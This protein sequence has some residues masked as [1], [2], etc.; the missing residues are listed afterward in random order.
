[1]PPPDD[2]AQEK[3]ARRPWLKRLLFIAVAIE[4]TWLA[5]INAALTLPVTQDLLNRI[6]PEKF[7]VRWERAWSWYPGQVSAIKPFANGQSRRQQWQASVDRVD[8]RI[9]LL[10]LILKRVHISWGEAHNAEYR[11]RPRLK[12]DTDYTLLLPHYPEI[13]GY[14]VVPVSDQPLPDRRPWKTV[15]GNV[16]V[17]G[18]HS[19]WIHQFR[20]DLEADLGGSLSVVAR[21]GPLEMD[22]D[23]IDIDLAGAWVNTDQPMIDSGR[24]EGQFGFVPFRPRENRGLPML[25]FVVADLEVSL[26]MRRLNFIDVFLL[27]FDDW[28]VDGNGA[29]TGRLVYD[30]GVMEPGTDLHVDA[31]DLRVEALALDVTGTGDIDLG[32]EDAA[33]SPLLLDFS[34]RGLTVRHQEDEVTMLEGDTLA[35][36]LSGSRNLDITD[37]G[38]DFDRTIAV[39]IQTL[40]VPDLS[41]LQ[42]FLP[43][44]WPFRLNGGEGRL[45]GRALLG[46]NVLS[47][48]LRLV[49]EHAD[50]A[51]KQYRFDTNLDATLRLENPDIQNQKTRVAGTGLRLSESRLQRDEGAVTQ[52]WVASLEIGE[53]ELSL[54]QPEDKQGGVNSFD[55]LRLMGEKDSRAL[56]AGSSGE[57]DFEAAVSSLAFLDVLLTSEEPASIRGDGR[58][59]GRLLLSEGLPDVGTRVSIRSDALGVS[60]MDYVARGDGQVDL[61][62]EE[63]G[64]APDWHLG[65]RL[66]EGTMNRQGDGVGGIEDVQLLLD[67]VVKDVSFDPGPRDFDLRFQIPSAIVP[68]MGL[69]NGYLPADS[70]LSFTGGTADMVLDLRLSHDDAQGFVR[71]FGERIDVDLDGQAVQTDLIA[72]LLVV[73]GQPRD[74]AFDLAGSTVAVENVRV[75][76]AEQAFSDEAWSATVLFERADTTWRQPPVLDVEATLRMSDSR[77]FVALMQNSG[78]PAFAGRVLT[79]EDIEGTALLMAA[80]NRIRVPSAEVTSNDITVGMKALIADAEREGMIFLR[81]KALRALLKVRDGKRN[82]DVINSRSTFDR[83][84]PPR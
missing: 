53:G 19:V 31:D 71:L 21:G 51:V 15:L 72:N 29:V 73:G 83:Y 30:Q 49:S 9:A 52:P 67:A 62:V 59:E 3:T 60:V 74:M 35:L 20:A 81:W 32:V 18:T 69:F 43:A 14:D 55:L 47:V 4:I 45:G 42:R 39:D 50:A 26:D 84:E 78:G 5:V 10:P 17:T 22:I 54:I 58:V 24:I 2:R 40:S 23:E 37:G 38:F 66:E 28:H 65:V 56:L 80:N 6:K 8:A 76:G 63:G 33:D 75:Q 41:L 44:K 79:V 36:Q 82:V 12:P 64:E 77:P 1:M 16:E 25:D 27:N 68:D 48:D 57:L 7:Q 70:P 34:F 61:T 11:Q 13:D 46:P